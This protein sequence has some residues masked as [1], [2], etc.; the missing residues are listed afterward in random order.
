MP[1]TK[2]DWQQK[3]L[4]SA[5]KENLKEHEKEKR[6]KKVDSVLDMCKTDINVEL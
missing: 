6:A 4:R 5:I 1:G 3:I 2:V